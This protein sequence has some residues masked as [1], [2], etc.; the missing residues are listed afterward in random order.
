MGTWTTSEWQDVLN[1]PT[2]RKS[3]AQPDTWVCRK[4][5]PT[6]RRPCT[7]RF[8]FLSCA[9]EL[10][11]SATTQKQ[12]LRGG[13]K[14]G[15]G[16]Q[17]QCRAS[18]ALTEED[19]TISNQWKRVRER[20]GGGS[21][22]TER[23]GEAIGWNRVRQAITI[24]SQLFPSSCYISHFWIARLLS[25]NGGREA[26]VW[27]PGQVCSIMPAREGQAHCSQRMSCH[28][29]PRSQEPEDAQLSRNWPR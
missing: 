24:S 25:K 1:R 10:D 19:K 21:K 6:Q 16:G 29:P 5:E 2:S 13:G 14:G 18:S 28:G 3:S 7:Q 20:R 17:G 23:C 22:I 11:R 8:R 12:L 15:G 26:E 4:L 9:N 27:T